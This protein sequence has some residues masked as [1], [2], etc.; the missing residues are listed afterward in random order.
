M[1]EAIFPSINPGPSGWLWKLPFKATPMFRTSIYTPANNRGELAVSLTLFPIFM[2]EFD[3]GYMFGKP[4]DANNG[5]QQFVGFYG[6]M[7]GQAST[8]L[9]SWPGN[10]TIAT[11]EVIGIGDG[12]TTQFLITRMTGGM[13]ELLQNFQNLTI[14]VGGAPLTPF[15]WS[16]DTYGVLTLNTAPAGPQQIS[17]SGSWYY[18]CRFLS[19]SLQDLT[20]IRGGTGPDFWTMKSLKF[21]SLL[22]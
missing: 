5:Y 11:P 13:K 10:N 17:W 15:D 14:Y 7:L 4:T 22:V 1:S 8:W 2:F 6:Q 20:L 9:F 3:I 16:I 19:D 18:R 21:K 12:T